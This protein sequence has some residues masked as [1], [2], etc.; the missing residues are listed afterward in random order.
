MHATNSS[1]LF[2]WLVSGGRR[3]VLYIQMTKMMQIDQDIFCWALV[4]NWVLINVL[5]V[6]N[7]IQV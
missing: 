2:I 7:V 4:Y 6:S 1:V 3:S 5:Q